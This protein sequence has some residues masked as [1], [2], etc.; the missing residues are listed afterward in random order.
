MNHLLTVPPDCNFLTLPLQ[1]DMRARW[2]Q[3]WTNCLKTK[4]CTR[5]KHNEILE[6]TWSYKDWKQ[7]DKVRT[8]WHILFL[9]TLS[10]CFISS[11]VAYLFSSPDCFWSSKELK[12]RMLNW[13]K[14]Q[15][16][17]L[18]PMM[19]LYICKLT[20]RCLMLLFW[21]VDWF[22]EIDF[23]IKWN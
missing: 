9:V 15:W 2:R 22:K 1:A 20:Q 17:P 23:S 11:C 4:T 6:R 8:K 16:R 3:H 7:I 12:R 21:H 19:L 14:Y 13:G 5:E 18:S 10:C